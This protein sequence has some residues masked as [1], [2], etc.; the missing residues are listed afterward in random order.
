VAIAW[1]IL[2]DRRYIMYLNL[3]LNT[4]DYEVMFWRGLNCAYP[5]KYYFSSKSYELHICFCFV[6]KNFNRS[7]TGFE[8]LSRLENLETLDLSYNNFNMSIIES[9]SAIKSLKN[10][11]LARNRITGS[12]PAQGMFIFHSAL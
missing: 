6:F 4:Y 3:S 5:V 1:K 2:T 8:S 11:N 10:L 7:T 9:L 12:F